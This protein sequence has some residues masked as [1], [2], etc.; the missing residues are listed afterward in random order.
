VT[1]TNG[2]DDRTNAADAVAAMLAVI[3]AA[4]MSCRRRVARVLKHDIA[5]TLHKTS[6]RPS[7]ENILTYIHIMKLTAQRQ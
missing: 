6:R 7:G 5:T 4:Q 1:P 3:A 2:C